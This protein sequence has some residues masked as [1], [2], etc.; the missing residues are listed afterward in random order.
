MDSNKGMKVHVHVYNERERIHVHV[1]MHITECHTFTHLA[2]CTEY[3]TCT[4]KLKACE[5]Q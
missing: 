2:Q 4:I 5:I 3:C 1:L